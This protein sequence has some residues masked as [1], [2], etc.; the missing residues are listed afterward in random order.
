MSCR[1][2]VHQISM[3]QTFML[4]PVGSGSRSSVITVMFCVTRCVEGLIRTPSR[5][6]VHVRMCN[7]CAQA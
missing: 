7:A 5:L 2:Y 4:A 6:C 3:R 1:C